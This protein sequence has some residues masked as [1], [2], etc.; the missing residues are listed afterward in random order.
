[1]SGIMSVSVRLLVWTTLLTCVSGFGGSMAYEGSDHRKSNAAGPGQAVPVTQ[2]FPYHTAGILGSESH[3]VPV[4]YA[5]G[6]RR[7]FPS[8]DPPLGLLGSGG[9]D[10]GRLSEQES[11]AHKISGESPQS[12]AGDPDGA[13]L[14]QEQQVDT[15]IYRPSRGVKG[16]ALPSDNLGIPQKPTAIVDAEIF[17]LEL[18]QELKDEGNLLPSQLNMLQSPVVSAQQA[19]SLL[20]AV[21]PSATETTPPR[22]P[23]QTPA[24]T[25]IEELPIIDAPHGAA[26]LTMGDWGLE[27]SPQR[28][29][30]AAMAQEARNLCSL[31]AGLV[32]LDARGPSQPEVRR[33]I[34][35]A[36]DGNLD[37]PQQAEARS[38][39]PT[40]TTGGGIVPSGG[41]GIDASTLTNSHPEPPAGALPAGTAG[42]DSSAKNA[43]L[44]QAGVEHLGSSTSNSAG[45]G[46]V[47]SARLPVA[48]TDVA[49]TS[50]RLASAGH[51]DVAAAAPAMQQL[52]TGRAQS[53][54]G[55]STPGTTGSGADGGPTGDTKQEPG[56]NQAQ[57]SN[58]NLAPQVEPSDPPPPSFVDASGSDTH[59]DVGSNDAIPRTGALDSKPVAF[60]INS[61]SA[62]AAPGLSISD[63]PAA[64]NQPAA[65]QAALSTVSSPNGSNVGH[66]RAKVVAVSQGSAI[67]DVGATGSNG[68]IG[69]SSDASGSASRVPVISGRASPAPPNSDESGPFVGGGGIISG[70]VESHASARDGI[71]RPSAGGDTLGTVA[72]VGEAAEPFGGSNVIQERKKT[73]S[74]S[75]PGANATSGGAAGQGECLKAVFVLGDNFYPYGITS[76]TD[77]HWSSTFDRVYAEAPLEQVPF[78]AVLG[79][80]DYLGDAFAQVARTYS[81]NRGRWTLPHPWYS[82]V[83]RL[84]V[85][86]SLPHH[87]HEPATKDADVA[88]AAAGAASRGVSS[89]GGTSPN[90]GASIG[91]LGESADVL[92]S[93]S[94]GGNDN[95]HEVVV[96]LVFI[97][98]ETLSDEIQTA[99][100]RGKEN[101]KNIAGTQLI[102]I[103]QTLRAAAVVSD[104]IFVIGHHP[105]ESSGLHGTNIQLQHKL[106]PLLVKYKADAYICGHDHM[107]ECLQSR[108]GGPTMIT[109]GSASK[110]RPV[111][112]QAPGSLFRYGSYGF[113][114]HLLTKE[115]LYTSF[116]SKDG[117][118]L[119]AYTHKAQDRHSFIASLEND[120]AE[121]AFPL[122]LPIYM[123][124]R[125]A[126][127]TT[128]NPDRLAVTH[129]PPVS[130]GV[131]GG[132]NSAPAW[133][134]AETARVAGPRVSSPFSSS[135]SRAI[136]QSVHT[137]VSPPDWR[138]S[139]NL[140]R[141]SPSSVFDL[142]PSYVPS[143]VSQWILPSAIIFAGIIVLVL[144]VVVAVWRSLRSRRTD[145]GILLP[146]RS[147]YARREFGKIKYGQ[148]PSQGDSALDNLAA[149]SPI[150]RTN[151]GTA[152]P[153]SNHSLQLPIGRRADQWATY[154]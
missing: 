90:R 133:G 143:R 116:I 97:D 67:V 124:P 95:L 128:V 45:G 28:Q 4:A 17:R 9:L 66:E 78:Y 73:Y 8:D 123:G 75:E 12:T 102:W 147:P 23:A 47:Q 33:L 89:E 144:C 104:W 24:L 137:S 57:P 6:V 64:H 125:S 120:P 146:V 48:A 46:V 2:V 20:L 132:G 103:D 38:G 43:N 3:A 113:T 121:A 62:A 55:A 98:T 154:E 29:V 148:L 72:V 27:G 86:A 77:S 81:S 53:A 68:D 35:T 119:F 140:L 99:D 30:A 31:A 14:R 105:I 59:S 7:L 145:S 40:S 44:A 131:A 76:V 88:R 94:T 39:A 21:R 126:W 153:N 25:I 32:A 135:S 5:G 50:A 56:N 74:V 26:F 152:M 13:A 61:P 134:G 19:Q 130:L 129:R 139:G 58:G 138:E 41:G 85:P 52:S 117:E 84:R 65:G 100:P 34:P 107:L 16:V 15:T 51:S 122:L 18:L 83:F 112:T 118:V 115:K 114:S 151:S 54:P 110:F 42:F 96:T 82:R 49:T 70:A 149:S 36:S 80:H 91:V 111:V 109:S 108:S 87:P 136:P 1:M 106:Q 79:N 101:L 92:S 150:A 141:G 69:V 63:S 142:T 22:R 127:A 71:S 93:S 60:V 10:A 11:R 37:V